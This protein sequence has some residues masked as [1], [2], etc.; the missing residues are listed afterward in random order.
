ML[1]I[2]PL[3]VVLSDDW[4]AGARTGLVAGYGAGLQAVVSPDIG[5]VMRF[6]ELVTEA[7]GGVPE[8]VQ[9]VIDFGSQAIAVFK[10][11]SPISIAGF[12]VA[13]IQLLAGR[14]KY[15]TELAGA[16]AESNA[17]QAQWDVASYLILKR[18]DYARDCPGGGM[19]VNSQ[20][21]WKKDWPEGAVPVI[22]PAVTRYQCADKN[23]GI[24][25][26][27]SYFSCHASQAG[28]TYEFERECILFN[29]KE[30][31]L[32]KNVEN[33]N[34]DCFALTDAKTAK[35]CKVPDFAKIGISLITYPLMVEDA[36]MPWGGAH[37]S[38]L[39]ALLT[40]PTLIHVKMSAVRVAILEE[41]IR[42]M[43]RRAFVV[44][45]GPPMSARAV[46]MYEDGTYAAPPASPSLGFASKAAW[47][48]VSPWVNRG[49]QPGPL[50]IPDEYFDLNCVSAALRAITRFRQ[51]RLA[52][53]RHFA[54]LP[55]DLQIAATNNPD[56][57][58]EALE[59]V[60]GPFAGRNSTKKGVTFTS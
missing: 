13:A 15:A 8:A 54:S 5:N 33:Y 9:N 22:P 23:K 57:N 35:Q 1:T 41:E 38:P 36:S 18:Q 37:L 28:K 40:T 7:L 51:C 60:G 16:V 49:E 27:P 45:H 6:G 19:Y 58:R 32:Q 39:A 48:K 47:E 21:G 59:A 2:P 4:I 26:Y 30:A 24:L 31:T 44:Q 42:R 3:E 52:C 11:G 29:A 46:T 43:V 25:A 55:V 10:G 14:L 17:L 20:P 34:S 53:M 56:F 50:R 12:A